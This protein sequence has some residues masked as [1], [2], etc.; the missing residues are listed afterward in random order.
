[1][2]D[3]IVNVY[4]NHVHLCF[5]VAFVDITDSISEFG[6]TSF[7]IRLISCDIFSLQ[8]KYT[9]RER[10]GEPIQIKHQD[11]QESKR[12]TSRGTYAKWQPST[13]TR[14]TS[15]GRNQSSVRQETSD[16]QQ[17]LTCHD[18]EWTSEN[19]MGQATNVRGTGSTLQHSTWLRWNCSPN[20]EVCN[21]TMWDLQTLHDLTW[22]KNWL[23]A[24][25]LEDM[26][27]WWVIACLNWSERDTWTITPITLFCCTGFIP[28]TH[29]FGRSFLLWAFGPRR[30]Y[31]GI[32]PSRGLTYKS[33][34]KKGW[35]RSL[36][37]WLPFLSY[38][39][40]PVLFSVVHGLC[41]ER[42]GRVSG[43]I[44][45]IIRSDPLL[46]WAAV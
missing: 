21:A 34:C 36:N 6:W 28:Q 17:T 26:L 22:P 2:H 41:E 25:W 40:N 18:G 13:Y 9:E 44:P 20:G 19:A 12:I 33:L 43:R 39:N 8:K 3:I 37:G 35:W 27:E 46:Q 5:Y 15:P 24:E 11:H 23:H 7:C 14:W 32:A 1:M 42:V 4:M 38:P 10:E 16:G 30:E 29:L 31:W 45:S